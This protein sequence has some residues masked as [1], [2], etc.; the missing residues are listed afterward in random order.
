[1]SCYRLTSRK[2]ICRQ[3]SGRVVEVEGGGGQHS[4][5]CGRRSALESE[6]ISPQHF[7]SCL[8]SSQRVRYGAQGA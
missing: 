6:V 2:L 8:G 3:E 5:T 4:P 1:V 7:I